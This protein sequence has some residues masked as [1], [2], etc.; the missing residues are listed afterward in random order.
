VI[1]GLVL[2]VCAGFLARILRTVSW[3]SNMALPR[4]HKGYM[5][6]DLVN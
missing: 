5:A 4:N 1:F 3:T 6:L 2:W